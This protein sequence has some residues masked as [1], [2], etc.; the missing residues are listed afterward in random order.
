MYT[1]FIQLGAILALPVYFRETIMK[2][3]STLPKRT[4]MSPVLPATFI[5]LISVAP[6]GAATNQSNDLWQSIDERS[7]D[8][9]ANRLIIP[10]AYRTVRLDNSVLAQVLASAP[11]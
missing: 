2:F 6:F 9:G 3:L 7:L 8:Q 11:M 4:R 1:I 10:M 5:L